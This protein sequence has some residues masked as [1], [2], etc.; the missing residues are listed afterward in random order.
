[1]ANVD[2]IPELFVAPRGLI[3]ILLFL[4]IPAKLQ[5]PQLEGVLLLTVLLTSLVMTLGLQLAHRQP[6]RLTPEEA[7]RT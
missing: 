2:L 1:M 4:S 3:T 7:E 5:L 6:T